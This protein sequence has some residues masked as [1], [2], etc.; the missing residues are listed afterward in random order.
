M[1]TNFPPEKEF[2]TETPRHRER[3]FYPPLCLC[4]S[5][6]IFLLIC[7]APLWLIP[8]AFSQTIL[9][10]PG[11]ASF[12]HK[13]ASGG[14]GGGTITQIFFT[15]AG[16]TSSAC[17]TAPATNTTG[18]TLFVSALGTYRP[19]FATNSSSPA[20]T[21]TTNQ[22]FSNGGSGYAVYLSRVSSP[23]T[24]SA[25]TFTASGG[26]A[27]ISALHVAVMGVSGATAL[28][29]EA[30]QTNN[31][32]IGTSG[33]IQVGGGLTPTQSGELCVVALRSDNTT[34]WS[35]DS[36]FTI[37][38]QITNSLAETLVFAH[39]IKTDA[40]VER[41]TFTKLT[42][43]LTDVAVVGALYK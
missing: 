25:Q 36:G 13:V 35:I 26:D 41:P 42:G 27:G 10:A 40:L 5:V 37:D 17:T 15:S 21:W 14:G 23:T 12:K 20:N 7:A 18:S 29:V 34:T 1:K 43:G 16:G 38:C 32:N 28:D 24:S 2:A 4:A 30:I 3:S 8:P 31:F 9:T 39:K 22:N 11:L 19:P 33:T 6:A